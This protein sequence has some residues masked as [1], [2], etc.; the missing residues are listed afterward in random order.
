MSAKRFKVV[1][2]LTLNV[3]ISTPALEK[4]IF[5]SMQTPCMPVGHADVTIAAYDEE[6]DITQYVPASTWGAN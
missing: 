3:P 5:A 2:E 6:P 1:M 4:S